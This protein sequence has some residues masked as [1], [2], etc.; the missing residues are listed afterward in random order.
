L[1]NLQGG[2]SP[3]LHKLALSL[4]PWEIRPLASFLA[5]KPL[6]Q[7]ELSFFFIFSHFLLPI[8]L[9]L[10]LALFPS[11]CFLIRNQYIAWDMRMKM[12]AELIS[13]QTV[14]LLMQDELF[15]S[16]RGKNTAIDLGGV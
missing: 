16:P 1:F 8:S 4:E 6:S 7:Q 2:Q 14:S 9:T 13:W 3:H 15:N 11:H 5:Q 12:K 10:N